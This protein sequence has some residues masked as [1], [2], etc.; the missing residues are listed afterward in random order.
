MAAVF[1][2]AAS[3]KGT[4]LFDG[5]DR[6]ETFLTGPVG[7]T[8][9]VIPVNDLTKFQSYGGIAWLDSEL[10][11]YTGLSAG[12][13]AGNLT[14][15]TRGY[16]GT[17]QTTHNANAPIGQRM[18]AEHLN[19]IID[20]VVAMEQ[21]LTG[22][23]PFLHG[24]TIKPAAAE[25][26]LTLDLQD[27]VG[28]T[29]SKFLSLQVAGVEKGN[30]SWDAALSEIQFNGITLEIG[31]SADL[32]ID[33]S[34]SLWFGTS[35]LTRFTYNAT[36]ARTEVSG[37]NLSFLNAAQ[38]SSGAGVAPDV[39]LARQAS[40][41]LEA[42]GSLAGSVR[43]GMS[44]AGTP[45]VALRAAAADANPMAQLSTTGVSFGVGG[46]TAT[47]ASLGRQAAAVL[48]LTG[49]VAGSVR[50]GMIGA[51]A[52]FLDL[53]LAA[54]DANP[55][56]EVLKDRVQFGAGGASAIDTTVFRQA[57]GILALPDGQA[58]AWGTNAPFQ[59]KYVSNASGGYLVRADG[60]YVI[61]TGVSDVGAAITAA[62]SAGALSILV[63]Y[64]TTPYSMAT[65]VTIPGGVTVDLGWGNTIQLATGHA[66]LTL[67]QVN[68][69]A[70]LLGCVIDLANYLDGNGNCTY[71][72]NVVAVDA[73]AANA[74]YQGHKPT[75]VRRF[76]FR[77]TTE[78]PIPDSPSSVLAHTLSGTA[79][80]VNSGGAVQ[81][82]AVY[83][84]TV[85]DIGILG[86]QY[87]IRLNLSTAVAFI[88][89]NTFDN[90]WTFDCANSINSTAFTPGLNIDGNLFV[91]IDIQSTK[92]SVTGVAIDGSNN[93]YHGQIW[94]WANQAPTSAKLNA[95]T[96]TTGSHFNDINLGTSKAST[97][98]RSQGITGADGAITS[99]TN[100]FAAATGVFVAAD[101][102]R[103]I[104]IAGAGA[105]GGAL[106]TTISG[107]TS[108]SSVTLTA[109][110]STT[111]AGATYS[112]QIADG[113]NYWKYNGA[114]SI[115]SAKFLQISGL[116]NS[117]D[118]ALLDAWGNKLLASFS[119]FNFGAGVG[120]YLLIT[121]GQANTN[122][123]KLGA[124]GTDATV[125]LL[126]EGKGVG[127]SVR[128]QDPN[129]GLTANA[130]LI[131]QPSIT[132]SG[133]AALYNVGLFGGNTL[134][135]NANQTGDFGSFRFAQTTIAENS[136]VA[137]ITNA[138][139]VIIDGAPIAGA[140]LTA[141]TNARALWVKA[142]LAQL[143]GNLG[144]GAGAGAADTYLI[145]QAA[146]VLA[147]S[148]NGANIAGT[149]YAQVFKAKNVGSG[150]DPSL[151]SASSGQNMDFNGVAFRPASDNGGQLGQPANR[152]SSV[153]A[154]QWRIFAA[155]NDA[156]PTM[157][158]SAGVLN[159]G[160]GGATAVDVILQRNANSDMK[161]T[162]SLAGD[163]RWG[164]TG[165]NTPRVS[166]RAATSDANHA[167]AVQVD[168]FE[169]GHGGASVV[170]VDL[171]RTGANALQLTAS[172]GITITGDLVGSADAARSVGT[173]TTRMLNVVANVHAIY[174]A[175]G[176]ANPVWR[177]SSAGVAYGVGG[178][179]ATD[180]LV[181]RQAASVLEVTGSVAGSVRYGMTG[182]GAPFLA[183]RAAAADANALVSF[184]STGLSLG[185]GGATAVDWTLL[186]TATQ[187]ATLTGLTI[188]AATSSQAGQSAAAVDL[189][190]GGT[191]QTV[192]FTTNQTGDVV[193]NHYYQK[194]IVNAGAVTITNAS[195]LKIDGAPI[196][197][198]TGTITNLYALWVAGGTTRFDGAL[199]TQNINPTSDATY[200]LGT[201]TLRW[202]NAIANV[203]A[204]YAAS[205]DAN[206]V[207]QASSAGMALGV[208][209]ATAT[210][211]LI[212][213]QAAGVVE[214]T[215]SLAGS[216][217]LGMSGAN[218]PFLA[219]RNA[220]ADANAKTLLGAG[221]LA[222]GPGGATAVRSY[223]FEQASNVLAAGNDGAT[224][225]G[226]FYAQNLK[227]KN[228][229]AGS[230]VTLASA[231]SSAIANIN[232]GLVP[233][234]DGSF[235][236]GL[237]SARWSN[238]F[239]AAFKTY[240]AGTDTVATVQLDS[241]WIS[242]GAGG[243]TA[244]DIFVK[245]QAA[246]I[247]ELTGSL[248][249]SVRYGM[250]AANT[251][252]LALRN[253][254]ADAN[255]LLQ[256]KTDRIELGPGGASVVD[257]D[258]RR[259]GANSLQL[260]ASSGI[261]VTG[262]LLASSDNARALG[263]TSNRMAHV[264][265]AELDLLSAA[266]GSVG[267]LVPAALTAARTWTFPD[268]TGTV[269]LTN[270]VAGLPIK[271]K[272]TPA[273]SGNITVT[274]QGTAVSVGTYTTNGNAL[275]A[276]QIKATT[277]PAATQ[278]LTLFIKVTFTDNTTLNLATH[279]DGG[280]ATTFDWNLSG[281]TVASAV[282]IDFP[283]EVGNQTKAIKQID[284]MAYGSSGTN[285]GTITNMLITG[286]DF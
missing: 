213:R 142:G 124:T 203:H 134:T 131:V 206:P 186:R 88:N 83:G 63:D 234:S 279:N 200:S 192:T 152:W 56:A 230:D 266:S 80:Y 273:N 113:K 61:P 181:A 115:I 4:N 70:T 49:S 271:R 182:A 215:G 144:I 35:E 199:S 175:S 226:T 138:T 48:E 42:T 33:D 110:A 282:S 78:E 60:V 81:G 239:S 87:G 246:S 21:V 6:A 40:S 237:G 71:T 173:A 121:P 92:N 151:S 107:Y 32:V 46:A 211:V 90:I 253:A 251:P 183:L 174:A 240:T 205:A 77:G 122:T 225:N 232:G 130:A 147:A 185:P 105:G 69:N 196:Q 209:G 120:N 204:V 16:G 116:A 7:S 198:A 38:F 146:G 212:A 98:D 41:I 193:A 54:G 11:R 137:A 275:L 197:G 216:V 76:R 15:V 82:L 128:F 218:T 1:P 157:Q 236:L 14:G 19:P 169:I 190:R 154:V 57:A 64:S 37:T 86:F 285:S 280:V 26:A 286:V 18:S 264:Y 58:F 65:G 119:T 219:L 13:G 260:T 207:W 258:L 188:F 178:A 59:Q 39:A 172:A 166:L 67:F 148:T 248:A 168:R 8:D 176:D 276:F 51:A 268:A 12:S 141:I 165:A 247:L 62:I 278:N 256:L 269:A 36:S 45:F 30:I 270:Q 133:S 244:L 75:T 117:P 179:T 149:F 50:Y 127:G 29:G 163:V 202:Q 20:E 171:R 242:L 44:G 114:D 254:A 72:G 17:V 94:D 145:R 158:A 97:A 255:P 135:F 277:A 208:G 129:T 118:G 108:P 243:S 125:H 217:R 221:S 161:L 100:T 99:G 164:M 283:S 160:A 123:V 159:F 156:N 281:A 228:T 222:F 223:I 187:T 231:S 189:V 85:E 259:T 31:P 126:L 74:T 136:V 47:D 229:G 23:A 101:V 194:T 66:S 24:L 241:N 34:R 214:L 235:N 263:S 95:I 245:R 150:G 170:D 162:G 55:A 28:A 96:V 261:T 139:T 112:L 227:I 140:N 111:V 79:I 195:T 43:Y 249:G 93:K 25:T 252:F 102:G 262:D 73:V 267:A 238:I 10:I 104:V 52:P 68:P 250:S 53:R 3:V 143:D 27:Q 89:G 191:T 257:V 2:A 103:T 91:N 167:A 210:D 224:V 201:S 233:S 177:A 274:S 153:D 272:V 5:Q 132:P 155:A 22:A 180:V 109:N 84:L 184:T 106:T 220:A 284:I 9:V 265:A